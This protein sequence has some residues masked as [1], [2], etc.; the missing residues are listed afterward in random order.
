MTAQAA[1]RPAEPRRPEP[2]AFE[3]PENR[4]AGGSSRLRSSLRFDGLFWRRFARL[5]CVYGPEWWKRYSPPWV[6]RLIFAIAHAN[7]Q[8]CMGNQAAVLG[9][10]PASEEARRAALRVFVAFARC[11]TEALEFTG[12]HRRPF[13]IDEPPVDHVLR[14][15]EDGRG[16]VLTTAHLGNWE[17][18]AALLHR[19]GRP[20]NLVMAREANETTQEY[21]RKTR[22]TSG[23]RVILSDSSIF[24][25]FNMIRA[26]R[27]NEIV[28]I[29]VDRAP[30]SPVAP[31]GYRRVELFG[32]E[33][34]FLEGPFH[35][36]RLAGAPVVPVFTL[37]RGTRHY[38]IRL[39]D[40]IHV[41]RSDPDD[42][43]R[44][45]RDTVALLEQTIREN[46][47]Q[48]FEFVPFWERTGGPAAP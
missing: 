40:P 29:Q 31:A 30:V 3:P 45:L 19:S 47:D 12:P 5:G 1:P 2:G 25:A 8:G 10:D 11:M 15:L 38:E 7:R 35:L 21:V 27:R 34:P 26:L 17:L 37:R 42:A 13:R 32:R 24:S 14:A 36:A 9:V 16:V 23:M 20:V 4:S 48:W 18:S 43:T 22:E 39:G 41:S 28:A 6:A 46:P 33:A 44:A